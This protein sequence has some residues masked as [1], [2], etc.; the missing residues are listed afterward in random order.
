MPK[1]RKVK[2]TPLGRRRTPQEIAADTKLVDE[3]GHRVAY[4]RAPTGHTIRI[5]ADDLARLVADGWSPAL[6]LACPS[7]LSAYVVTRKLGGGRCHD[8]IVGRLVMGARDDETVRY[9]NSRDDV[10]RASLA[11]VKSPSMAARAAARALRVAVNEAEIAG[12]EMAC[13]AA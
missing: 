6:R 1:K 10:R 11:V 4:V 5:D 2:W 7:G 13:Q 9:L 3:G 12:G 8:A